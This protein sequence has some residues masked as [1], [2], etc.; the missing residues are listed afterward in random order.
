MRCSRRRCG[1]A[2]RGS[3]AA[4]DFIGVFAD[5][6]A[7]SLNRRMGAPPSVSLV[8]SDISGACQREPG[9][10]VPYN[11]AEEPWT[12][13]SRNSNAAAM[14]GRRALSQPPVFG[15][16][17]SRRAEQ[18]PCGPADL[19]VLARPDGR[20]RPN[21]ARQ[22]QRSPGR[23]CGRRLRTCS[24]PTAPV[25]KIALRRLQRGHVRPPPVQ[26]HLRVQAASA[27]LRALVVLA[28]APG[29]R[30]GDF[31]G[32]TVHERRFLRREARVDLRRA[33]VR[34]TPRFLGPPK[35]AEQRSHGG[36]CR[37]SS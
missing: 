33:H 23:S 6:G 16:A 36:G 19:R 18:G 20:W 25:D 28:A 22:V 9:V 35:T 24:S 37:R 31:L 11:R 12:P 34:G 30:S 14:R 15:F 26:D 29:R 27:R 13:E 21:A 4:D 10:T 5:D 1:S 17:R 7:S 3:P 32:L 8:V 2:T